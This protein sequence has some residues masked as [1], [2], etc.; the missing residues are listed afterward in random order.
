MSY[1]NITGQD[2]N[3]AI[4]ETL[5][6]ANEANAEVIPAGTKMA[7]KK[8]EYEIAVASEMYVLRDEGVPVSI[9]E[10]LAKGKEEIAAIG[11]EVEA[12]K[13]IYEASKTEISLRQTEMKVLNDMANREWGAR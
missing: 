7:Q 12:S 1:T 4:I 11:A 10:K 3:V 5:Q 13:V 6:Q 8:A 9:V 2:I